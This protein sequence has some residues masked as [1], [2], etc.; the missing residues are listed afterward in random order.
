MSRWAVVLLALWGCGGGGLDEPDEEGCGPGDP[1][2]DGDGVCDA[3]DPCPL[4]NPDDPDGDGKCGVTSPKEPPEEEEECILPEVDVEDVGPVEGIFYPDQMSIEFRGILEDGRWIDTEFDGKPDTAWLRLNFYRDDVH[5]CDAW[6]DLQDVAQPVGALAG[7][8]D[9]LRDWP[10]KTGVPLFEAWD[11]VLTSPSW[12]NCQ[13]LHHFYGTEDPRA[14]AN[15]FLIGLGLGPV[16]E[17]G[18]QIKGAVGEQKWASD[19]EPYLFSVYISTFGQAARE[20]GF[21]MGYEYDCAD[22]VR[23]PQ[24]K[25]TIRLPKPESELLDGAYEAYEWTRIDLPWS[26]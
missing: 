22:L 8:V 13:H 9:P 1:D 23:D 3:E 14:Y 19:Y 6:Y 20:L 7:E 21:V 11:M 15:Q 16:T 5:I 17:L 26:G 10:E 25:G 12:T 18:D 2:R 4:H 24:T